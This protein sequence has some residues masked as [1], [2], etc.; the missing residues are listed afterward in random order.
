MYWETKSQLLLVFGLSLG[1]LENQEFP[2]PLGLRSGQRHLL[3]Q[4][5]LVCL[6]V[7]LVVQAA[8]QTQWHL[9]HLEGQEIHQ[10]LALLP[11]L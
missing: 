9:L 6:V 11:I 5:P 2:L 8:Q 7:L 4:L 10:I 1:V 3:D